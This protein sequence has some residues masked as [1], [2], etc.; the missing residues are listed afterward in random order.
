M[1]RDL[2]REGPSDKIAARMDAERAERTSGVRVG[3]RLGLAASAASLLL[4]ACAVTTTATG[5]REGSPSAIAGRILARYQRETGSKPLT[6]GG[7]IRLRLFR[8]SGETESSGSAEIL[9]EPFRYRESTSSAGWTSTRG[10]EQGKAYFTDPDGVTRVVSDPVLRELTTRSYFWRRAWLFRDREG[11]RLRL[12]P[13][14]DDEVSMSLQ[15]SG[16]NPLLLTFSSRDGRLRSVRSPRFDLAFSSPTRFEDRSDPNHVFAGEIAWT[17]LPT[18]TIPHAEVGGGRARFAQTSSRVPFDR[19]GGAVVV[20]ARIGG[21]PAR[22][23]V[24][25]AADGF[26][27]ISPGLGERLR[28]AWRPDVL[29]RRV[30]GGVAL[31]A[32]AAAYPALFVEEAP[33]PAGVDAVAGGCLFR[34]AIV[35]FD[36]DARQL[37]LHD[38][39]RWVIPEAFV[40]VVIDDDGDR[41]VAILDRGSHSLRV[42]AGSDIGDAAL[43]LAPESARREGIDPGPKV[44]GMFWGSLKLEPLGL[45]L[46][47]RANAY[48]PDW[49]DDGRMGLALLL[50]FHAYVNMPQRWVYLRTA[51][52]PPSAAGVSGSPTRLPTR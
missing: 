6:A 25:A 4:A 19:T 3:R 12:G 46:S 2:A 15:P 20:P 48:A 47:D 52:G 27:R 8:P 21:E 36:P 10:I 35:E 37:G 13:A 33:L 45:R 9:W 31:E 11:A 5:C 18:G 42:A 24:D 50:R 39:E 32:G 14:T 1:A 43:E 49:G 41:P 51:P 7:M 38:P 22:L 34:E 28:L 29:G 30:A 17:G 23:A 40:R 26:V 16:G 44:S